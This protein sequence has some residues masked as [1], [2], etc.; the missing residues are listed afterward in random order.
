MS[1]GF[2]ISF[3][4]I[5]LDFSNGSMIF[6]LHKIAAKVRPFQKATLTPSFLVFTVFALNFRE[7]GDEQYR[8][9]TYTVK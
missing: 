6:N 8:K 5:V 1:Q 9:G 3:V 7:F 2:A 4:D